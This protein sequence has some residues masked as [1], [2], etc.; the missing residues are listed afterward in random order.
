MIDFSWDPSKPCEPDHL[1]LM[2]E[3]QPFEFARPE[4]WNELWLISGG[5]INP[6]V[7]LTLTILGKASWKKIFHYWLAQYLGALAASAVVYGVYYGKYK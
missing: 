4:G 7:T 6:A 3:L 1:L 2:A 5:H